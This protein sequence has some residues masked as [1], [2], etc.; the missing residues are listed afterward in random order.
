MDCLRNS[1]HRREL[2]NVY[3]VITG[4]NYFLNNNNVVIQKDGLAM[5]APSPSIFSEIFIQHIQ[6]T[7][8]P[9]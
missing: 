7:H 1:D 5:D 2:L 6:H 4:Q 8:L 9:Q 3:E